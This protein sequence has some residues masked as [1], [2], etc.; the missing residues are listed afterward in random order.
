[1]RS[2]KQPRRVEAASLLVVLCDD[3]VRMSKSSQGCELEEEVPPR[4]E[5]T[6]CVAVAE[7]QGCGSSDVHVFCLRRES[8]L[9]VSLSLF[10]SCFVPQPT[11][12]GRVSLRQF[13][14]IGF[15]GLAKLNRPPRSYQGF[16]RDGGHLAHKGRELVTTRAVPT[17][18]YGPHSESCTLV[19]V[20]R[21]QNPRCGSFQCITLP[22]RRRCHLQRKVC[23]C[24]DKPHFRDSRRSSHLAGETRK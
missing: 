11:S 21:K 8:V 22:D 6:D 24:S 7:I 3:G 16:S 1:M 10:V 5:F 12:L 14:R 23:D 18:M 9:K 17:K 4:I 2:S 20:I 15:F 19:R 13:H